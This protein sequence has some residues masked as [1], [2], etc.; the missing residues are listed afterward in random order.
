MEPAKVAHRHE[1]AVAAHETVGC[2][3]TGQ[4]HHEMGHVWEEGDSAFRRAQP[5]HFN[6]A[7]MRRRHGVWPEGSGAQGPVWARF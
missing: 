5:C 7:C 6:P 2:Q 1:I 3:C 4:E